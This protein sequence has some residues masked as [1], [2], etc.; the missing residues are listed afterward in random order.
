MSN[1]FIIV[2]LAEPLSKH[3]ITPLGAKFFFAT[4]SPFCKGGFR[5]NVDTYLV[6]LTKP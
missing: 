3:R 6:F 2:F 4:K 1:R 5:G